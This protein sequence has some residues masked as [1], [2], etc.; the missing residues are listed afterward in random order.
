MKQSFAEFG[1]SF[2]H[3]SR[4]SAPIHHETAQEL[5]RDLYEKGEFLEQTTEQYFDE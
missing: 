1:I 5:F 2:D 3:Y 4:T